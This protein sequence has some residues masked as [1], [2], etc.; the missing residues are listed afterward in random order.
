MKLT[1]RVLT[2]CVCVCVCVQE[3][4]ADMFARVERTYLMGLRAPQPELRQ[5]F[6]ALY[7]AAI[8]CTLYDR[9]LFTASAQEWENAANQFWL[10]HALVRWA[11]P[12][13][14]WGADFKPLEKHKIRPSAQ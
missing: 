13:M 6:F 12:C 4:R 9:L 3:L 10:T 14:V 8:P 5:R 11:S 7:H 2:V 1:H